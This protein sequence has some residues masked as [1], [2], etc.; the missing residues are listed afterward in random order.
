MT[1]AFAP[2]NEFPTYRVTKEKWRE[3]YKK[4][5]KPVKIDMIWFIAV[6]KVFAGC[7]HLFV[8]LPRSVGRSCL[9]STSVWAEPLLPACCQAIFPQNTMHLGYTPM[10]PCAPG[11]S[12]SLQQHTNKQTNKRRSR[13]PYGLFVSFISYTIYN[14]VDE[15]YKANR[16]FLDANIPDEPWSD[17]I[18]DVLPFF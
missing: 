4:K 12:G 2:W 18:D 11:L 14:T 7:K 17:V 10:C 13:S 6:F 1:G 8:G 16:G 9:S 5:K 3:E 15:F